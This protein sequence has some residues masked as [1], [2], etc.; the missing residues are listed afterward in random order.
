MNNMY[1]NILLLVSTTIFG[2]LVSGKDCN[3]LSEIFTEYGIE[4][5]WEDG[6]NGCCE[7]YKNYEYPILVNCN[8]DSKIVKVHMADLYLDDKP[9]S[10]Q[11]CHLNSLISLE[12]I[13]NG[14]AG[15]LPAC[16]TSLNTLEYLNLTGNKLTGSILSDIDK[17]RNLKELTLS[18]NNLS[19][20][21]PEAIGNIASLE[22]LYLDNNQI[23]GIL[24]NSL[25]NLASIKAIDLSFN[26]FYGS[27]PEEIYNLESLEQLYLN[28]N[29][30]SGSISEDLGSFSVITELDITN[31]M[32]VGKIPETIGYL[33][34]LEWLSV[35]GNQFSDEFPVNLGKL[36]Y[37]THLDISDN[38]F[39]SLPESLKRLKYL[40][41]IDLSDNKNFIGEIDL[42]D[43]VETCYMSTKNVCVNGGSCKNRI[44][45]C[46]PVVDA[47]AK[48]DEDE[49]VT[50]DNV[51]S[52][53]NKTSSSSSSTC[54]VSVYGYPCCEGK[55][56]EH[57]YATDN[58]GKWGYDF[59]KKIWCGISSYEE[60]ANKYNSMKKSDGDCWSLEQGYNCCVGCTTF[61]TTDEGNWGI[62][63]AEWCGIPSYCS[64]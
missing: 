36:R 8:Q 13:N 21:L 3:I 57:V 52:D 46:I 64:A 39:L 12:L 1:F 49:E 51:V 29:G 63:N 62:E 43:S 16:L 25:D 55:I 38:N 30:F 34:N 61:L 19:G 56:K 37:L 18:K 14:L 40:N 15:N 35:A 5:N 59:S 24:P 28:D 47:L 41:Y 6:T 33:Q 48:E 60:I 17:L 32:F 45:E 4:K 23:T 27:L 58:D 22:Y 54:W 9:I 20:K 31:N 10:E 2:S 42:A 44:R 11:F 53:S 7:S 26:Q 50:E